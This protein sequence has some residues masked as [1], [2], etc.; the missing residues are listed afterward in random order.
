MDTFFICLFVNSIILFCICWI[1]NKRCKG[2]YDQWVKLTRDIRK[3]FSIQRYGD[4]LNKEKSYDFLNFL[5]K[6]YGKFDKDQIQYIDKL[7]EH[8][9]KSIF[10]YKVKQVK[11]FRYYEIQPSKN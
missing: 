6:G 11:D 2:T 5:D 3:R 1:K 8:L 4:F 9:D 10:D 7:M